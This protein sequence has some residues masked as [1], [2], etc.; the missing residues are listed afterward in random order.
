[1]KKLYYT[2]LCLIISALFLSSCENEDTMQEVKYI[3]F[4]KVTK[5]ELSPNG[6][7]LIADGKSELRFLVKCYYAI[8][9]SVQKPMIMDRVPLDKIKITSSDNKTFKIDEGY[10]TTLSSDSV[11]FTCSI[12]NKISNKVAV[13][14]TTKEQPIFDKIVVPIIFHAIYTDKTESNTNA[15]TEEYI[16]KILARANKVFAGELFNSPSSCPSG[17]EFKLAKI[18]KV[19]VTDEVNDGWGTLPKYIAENLMENPDKYLNIWVCESAP[20]KLKIGKCVPRYTLGNKNDILGLKLKE[21]GSKDEISD[22]K[23]QDV[24]FAVSFY[25]IYQMLSGNTGDKRFE[26]LLGIYYGLLPTAHNEKNSPMVNN[27]LDY[28]A[29]TYSYIKGE[30]TRQKKTF[31]IDGNKDKRYYFDSYNIMDE[32]S[33]CTTIS[34]EQVKRIRQVIK[35]CAFRQMKE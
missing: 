26:R 2:L 9:D 10:T 18:N 25:N 32:Y 14:L 22:V 7:Q 27:D 30:Y 29:D 15:F 28:C 1:M 31:P 5:I 19:K 3:G 8:N 6:T 23:P 34:R 13:A 35:D 4:D 21:I 33:S 12:G 16:N 20:Y 11:Y 24:G 17:I